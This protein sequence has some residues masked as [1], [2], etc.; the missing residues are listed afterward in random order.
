MYTI[1]ILI[2]LFIVLPIVISTIHEKKKT[3][4]G[5]ITT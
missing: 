2:V 4:G 3:S 5:Y 1:P